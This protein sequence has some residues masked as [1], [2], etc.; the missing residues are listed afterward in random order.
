M[1]IILNYLLVEYAGSP[2]GR[3]FLLR[4]EE[5]VY[6]S[7]VAPQTTIGQRPVVWSKIL[8]ARPSPA[9]IPIF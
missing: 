8:E 3:L 6:V 1:T 5:D 4:N 7:E 2:R 9:Q